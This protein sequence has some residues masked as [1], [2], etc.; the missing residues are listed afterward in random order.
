MKFLFF[1]KNF[2]VTFYFQKNHVLSYK[3]HPLEDGGTDN[4]AF[5]HIEPNSTDRSG[6][7]NG[8]RLWSNPELDRDYHVM[9]VFFFFNMF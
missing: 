5:N 3:L 2:H 7:M 1:K 4:P 9:P 6:K 8:T